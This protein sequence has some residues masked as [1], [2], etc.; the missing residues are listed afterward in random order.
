MFDTPSGAKGLGSALTETHGCGQVA[1]RT[2]KRFMLGVVC[3]I[4]PCGGKVRTTSALE[5]ADFLKDGSLAV[6]VEGWQ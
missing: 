1:S 6:L 4:P 5:G 3:L 2:V